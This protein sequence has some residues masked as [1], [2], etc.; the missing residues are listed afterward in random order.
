[1][2]CVAPTQLFDGSRPDYTNTYV[3]TSPKTSLTE[4]T[5]TGLTQ[6][7]EVPLL[8]FDTNVGEYVAYTID[9]QPVKLTYDNP[10]VLVEGGKTYMLDTSQVNGDPDVKV[11]TKLQPLQGMTSQT[12][13]YTPVG[14]STA[15]PVEI[16][17]YSLDAEPV[18]YNIATGERIVNPIGTF[19]LD[20]VNEERHFISA[21]TITNRG[22]ITAPVNAKEAHLSNESEEIA[23]ISYDGTNWT[24]FPAGSKAVFT[25]DIDMLKVKS[26]PSVVDKDNFT[27]H[28]RVEL[29]DYNG[30]NYDSF[31][32]ESGD[33]NLDGTRIQLNK[34]YSSEYFTIFAITSN[35]GF[36]NSDGSLTPIDPND[37]KLELIF[38]NGTKHIITSQYTQLGFQSWPEW[39]EFR[40]A[41]NINIVANYFG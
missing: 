9:G 19:T 4:V 41:S 39:V 24:S 34:T 6:G 16:V 33:R 38:D 10:T 30:S 28:F 22:N 27:Y 40:V 23:Y 36:R 3:F 17:R 25:T 37:V 26:A 14:S 15:I 18:I 32:I 13:Y 1:M 5:A 12:A 7:Q 8:V 35:L 21:E 31:V 2:A 11:T 29:Q 20:K